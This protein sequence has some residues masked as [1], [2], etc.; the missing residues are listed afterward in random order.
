MSASF[1]DRN[2]GEIAATLPG[3]TAI[4]RRHK[5]DFC[6]G[7]GIP[8][9]E[10]AAKRAAPLGEIEAD[11]AALTPSDAA[12]PQSTGALI[13]LIVARYHDTHRRELPELI[14]LARR[15]ERV[16]ADNPDVPAGLAD[17]LA[18]MAAELSDHMAKEENVLFPM[19]RRGGHP[20]IAQPIA[21]MRHEHDDHGEHLEQMDRL[22]H[23]GV[24]PAGACNSWRALYA[25][26]RKLAEDLT[27]HVHIEN[28]ILFPRFVG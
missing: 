16:H 23:G 25:G 13:D 8:L 19:M 26:T 2:I 17:L 3:A 15:V 9:A 22:T 12:L 27:E 11:L 5:L 18:T 1:A 20:M 6:C 4:F 7:G 24:P 28:N 21:M 10:A 14:S